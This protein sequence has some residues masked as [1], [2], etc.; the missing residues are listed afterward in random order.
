MK[1]NRGSDLRAE[2][3]FAHMKGG[4]RG[5]YV[6]RYRSGTNLVLLDPQ[7]AR[8]F[9]TDAAVNDTLRAVLKISDSLRAPKGSPEKR[10]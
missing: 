6:S 8:A 10:R 3:D 1:K 4:I 5:K 2:Y 9:P 7:V